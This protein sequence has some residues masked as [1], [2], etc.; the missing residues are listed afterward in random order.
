MSSRFQRSIKIAKG[1]RLNVSKS[2]LGVSVGPRGAKLS[3]GPRGVYTSMGIP[4][5]GMSTRQKIS[6]PTNKSQKIQNSTGID[7][8]IRVE[9]SID[10]E[11]GKETISLFDNEKKIND[12]TLLRKVKK[13]PSFKLKLEK[14]RQKVYLDI[15]E[16]TNVLIEIHKHSE[17]MTNWQK[18]SDEIGVTKPLKYTK[19]EYDIK[20]PEKNEVLIDLQAEAKR[21]I[22]SLFGI[23]KKRQ[24]YVEERIDEHYLKIFNKWNKEKN[25]FEKNENDREVKENKKFQ[26]EYYNWMKEMNRLLNPDIPFI[27]ERLEDLFSEIQLPVDFSISFEVRNSGKEILLDIDLPEIEDFPSKKVQQLA[28]GKISIKDKTK[29]ELKEDYFT[30]ITGISIYF[31]S[32][33]FSAAPII[34]NV[35]LSGYTQRV[36]KATGNIEDEYVYSVKY[37]KVGF[38]KLNFLDIDPKLTLQSFENRLEVSTTYELKRLNHLFR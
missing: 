8:S 29:K 36:N 33:V 4:G 23:K 7:R 18:I 3:I 19:K 30:S 5:T 34:E 10:D 13:D 37:D 2:G 27:E 35:I 25:D 26:D 32:I 22:K 15:T 28:S 11:T 12:E 20:V 31:A 38:S 16:K 6:G 9:I 14:V 1:V 21:T 24:L 17:N